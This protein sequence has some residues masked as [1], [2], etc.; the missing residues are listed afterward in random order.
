M[1][2][3]QVKKIPWNPTLDW[4]RF[5]EDDLVQL[6]NGNRLMRVVDKT[7]VER[8]GVLKVKC[9]LLHTDEAGDIFWCS[10]YRL[11]P[12]EGFYK[13]ALTDKDWKDVNARHSN[14]LGRE[15]DKLPPGQEEKITPILTTTTAIEYELEIN[16]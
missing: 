3:Y 15:V 4:Y 10:Y 8:G 12:F 14:K 9:Q 16:P 13:H 6:I 5:M 1:A 7:Y 2:D 11:E